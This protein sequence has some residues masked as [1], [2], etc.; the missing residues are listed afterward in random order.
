MKYMRYYETLYLIRPDLEPEEY[1]SVIQKYN[2][3]IEDNEGIITKVEEWGKR[4]LA[5]EVEKFKDGFY[6]LVRF[7]GDA[8][9]P[10]KL[11]RDFRIDE[12]VLKFIVI[13]L[14]DKVNPE[15][16]KGEISDEKSKDEEVKAKDGSK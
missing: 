9:L 11:Q 15:E 10:E 3:I 8:D 13:K 2:K 4:E 6:V 14:K 7:C 16:L 1:K 12:R 5:Y